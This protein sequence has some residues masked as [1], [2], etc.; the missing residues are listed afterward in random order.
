MISSVKVLQF[1]RASAQ[2]K[3]IESL[4]QN[5][6]AADIFHNPEVSPPTWHFIISRAPSSEILYWGQEKSLSGARSAAAATL[7]ALGSQAQVG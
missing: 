1:N 3:A 6:F 5:G 4:E 2:A 7:A